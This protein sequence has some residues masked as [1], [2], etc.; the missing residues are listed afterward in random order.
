LRCLSIV[1]VVVMHCAAPL[2]GSPDDSAVWAGVTYSALS[3]FCVPALL[4][5][6]GALMLGDTRPVTLS[7]FYGKR[8]AKIALPLLAWSLIYYLIAC[9]M[10]QSAPHPV[11]FLKRFLTGVW[12]GPLW[13]LYMI[14]AVY[15]MVPFLRPAFGDAR[16]DRALLFVGLV[17][18][19]HALTFA[20]RLIWEQE[21][22]RFFSGALIPY[23][24]G[25]F[26]LG[27]V[28]NVRQI[29][30]PGAKPALALIFLACALTSA[31]G[32][33][34]VRGAGNTLLPNTFFN[35]QQ[36]LTVVM[37]ASIFLLFK[38]WKPRPSGRRDRFVHE[39]SGLSYGVFLTH[40][41]FLYLLGGQIP[42]FF[43]PGQG[44]DWNTGGPWVGPLLMGA[45]VF[46]GSAVLTW[47]VKKTPWLEKIIP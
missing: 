30:V 8:F 7:K 11:S 45:A 29:R 12:A 17:F 3:L 13:F 26:V 34:L 15:L 19:V 25:Y 42:L 37:S 31:W 5:I 10:T 47:G 35:Y 27:H 22:N 9:V 46:A 20:T 1:G 36:P 16:S 21:V 18:G 32:E 33:H 43:A 39:L 4:M 23:Y 40:V 2:L 6:S 24:F 28:L 14:A 44:L 41:L 38:G